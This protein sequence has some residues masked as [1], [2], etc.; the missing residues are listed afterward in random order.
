MSEWKQVAPISD[1]PIN[2]L[3][4][5]QVDNEA[6]LIYRTAEG[7]HAYPDLCTHEA[8]PLSDGYLVK[9]IVICRLHGAKYD[10]RTGACLKAP[11]RADL[12]AY[13]VQIVGGILYM[14]GSSAQSL[15]R[16]P[17][18]TIRSRRPTHQHVT[19]RL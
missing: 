7:V 11:A 13:A 1:I 19:Q 12:Q 4:R 2:Q 16:P 3:T 14:E 15:H 8:V 17:Q 6:I 18:M 10:L 5:V 9:D